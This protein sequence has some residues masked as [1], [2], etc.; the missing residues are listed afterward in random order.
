MLLL[1]WDNLLHRWHTWRNA[2]IPLAVD[3]AHVNREHR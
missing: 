1:F 2:Q 3:L